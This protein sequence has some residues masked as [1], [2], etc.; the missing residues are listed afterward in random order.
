[1]Q[2]RRPADGWREGGYPYRYLLSRRTYERQKYGLQVDLLKL[3]AWV[4]DTG[5]RV[6]V[7]FEGRDEAGNGTSSAMCST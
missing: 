2:R 6:S 5:A 1:M 7:L 4:K 3:Q